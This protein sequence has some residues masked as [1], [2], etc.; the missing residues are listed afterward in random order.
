MICKFC[1]VFCVSISEFTSASVG[2]AVLVAT[3]SSSAVKSAS[4][5]PALALLV[6]GETR[7]VLVSLL[8]K[9]R[10]TFLESFH[11]HVF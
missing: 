7:L 2:L 3:D 11:E 4:E 8:L 5:T 6:R 10:E 9:G 1:A